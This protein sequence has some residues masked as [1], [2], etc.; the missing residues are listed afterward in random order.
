MKCEGNKTYAKAGKC[1]ECNMALSN[2]Q[3]EIEAYTCPMNCETDKIYT[4]AGKCPVC[5]MKLAKVKTKKAAPGH[6]GHT[7]N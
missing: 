2:V 5:N 4:K 3:K 6:E 1:P 7:H